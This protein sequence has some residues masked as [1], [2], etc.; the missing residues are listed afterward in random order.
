MAIKFYKLFDLLN[1]R[2]ITK[3]KMRIDIGISTKTLARISAHEHVSM[4]VLEKLCM[5]LDVQPGD[6]LEYEHDDSLK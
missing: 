3:T 5:Y 1:R 2:N 6:L 4:D